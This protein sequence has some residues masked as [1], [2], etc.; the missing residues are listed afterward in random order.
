MAEGDLAVAA[1]YIGFG[2][3]VDA[4]IDGDAAGPVGAD[5]GEGIAVAAEEAA[6]R[7]RVVLVVDA[8]EANP[9]LLGEFEE[10]RV[11]FVTGHAPRR[12]HIDDG[13][14]ALGEVR[15]LKSFRVSEA[16]DRR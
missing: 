6:R 11:L 5:A 15:S 7:S 3:P 4:P 12:P 1:D 8:V 14:F 2:N 16:L 13:W 9:W 10:Q